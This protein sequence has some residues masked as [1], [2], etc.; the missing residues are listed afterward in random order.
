[1]TVLVG[2]SP[3]LFEFVSFELHLTIAIYVSVNAVEMVKFA[4][5]KIT[6]NTQKYLVQAHFGCRLILQAFLVA[7]LFLLY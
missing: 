1:V 5:P 3:N 2:F 6:F 7:N 4:S